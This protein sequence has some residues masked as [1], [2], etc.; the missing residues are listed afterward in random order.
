MSSLTNVK[1]LKVIFTDCLAFQIVSKGD[2]TVTRLRALLEERKKGKKPLLLAPAP[3]ACTCPRLPV[4]WVTFV[5]S[6]P[7]PVTPNLLSLSCVQRLTEKLPCQSTGFVF[8]GGERRQGFWG[9][10][11]EVALSEALLLVLGPMAHCLA[12]R[13]SWLPHVPPL[14]FLSPPPL[15]PCSSSSALPVLPHFIT[16]YGNQ[17]N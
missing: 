2:F 15:L 5:L 8:T 11:L 1:H 13:F 4:P 10:I 7:T 12:S 9:L 3:L 6:A 17:E 16:Y 14:M